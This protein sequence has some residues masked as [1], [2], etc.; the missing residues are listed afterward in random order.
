MTKSAKI[1]R[2]VTCNKCIV[3]ATVTLLSH[4][5]TILKTFDIEITAL[6]VQ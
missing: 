1:L 2:N 3:S 4:L 6:Y 5:Q